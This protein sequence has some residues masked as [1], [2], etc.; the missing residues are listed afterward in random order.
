[1]AL[2]KSLIW[3]SLEKARGKDDP[4]KKTGWWLSLGLTSGVQFASEQ[5][6]SVNYIY[7][8]VIS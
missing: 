6:I 3:L 5:I 7:F 4:G 1:M 8:Q 2:T